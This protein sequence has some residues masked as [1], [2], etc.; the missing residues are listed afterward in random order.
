MVAAGYL[1]RNNG[2]VV[3]Q[4]E[5]LDMMSPNTL[6]LHRLG[7]RHTHTHQ[8]LPGSTAP[9]EHTGVLGC[10]YLHGVGLFGVLEVDDAE[11]KRVLGTVQQHQGGALRVEEI[12]RASCRGRV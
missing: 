12:G 4:D 9:A 10:D 7:L 6:L 11:Q 5:P 1:L 8:N 2:V 3:L